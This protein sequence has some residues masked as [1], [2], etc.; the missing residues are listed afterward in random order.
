MSHGD[1]SSEVRLAAVSPNKVSSRPASGPPAGSPPVAHEG[2]GLPLI[3]GQPS[4]EEWWN[5][6][7][8]KLVARMDELSGDVI[9]WWADEDRATGDGRANACVL[10]AKALL[11]ALPGWN[12]QRRAVYSLSGFQF[13]PGAH[14]QV[15]VQGYGRIASGAS[16]QS[17]S[18]PAQSHAGAPEIHGLTDSARGQLG[19]LPPQGQALLQAPFTGGDEVLRAAWWYEGFPDRIGTYIFVLAGHRSVTAA[20]GSNY[21]PAGGHSE[22]PIWTLMCHRFA[23]VRRFGR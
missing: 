3:H 20:V 5:T 10:G 8:P 21:V 19:N 4:R 18:G 13:D 14:R 17:R 2:S 22:A 9:A 15:P 12:D 6:L 11:L 23:V 1:G 7:G 16:G